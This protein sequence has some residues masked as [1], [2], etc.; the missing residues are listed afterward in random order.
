M[1]NERLRRLTLTAVFLTLGFVL[2]F[3]TAQLPQFGNMLLPMHYP[4]LLCGFF[5][6]W[7][8]GLFLGLT[9]PLL[10]SLLFGA[11]PLMPIAAAMAV[12]LAAYGFISGFVYGRFPKRGPAALYGALLAAMLGGRL[13]WGAAMAVLLGINGQAF[14]LKMFAVGAFVLALPGIALQ[15]VLIPALVSAYAA[16][17][18]KPD[19]DIAG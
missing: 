16:G 6:G 2:P 8:Y 4:V 19:I 9:L 18:E 5:C 10:R 13:L 11:P 3:L 7:R 1:R 14:T 15:L 17:R 12:E